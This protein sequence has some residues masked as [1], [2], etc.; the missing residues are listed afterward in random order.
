M[1]R[2]LGL[3]AALAAL[4][5]A[6][7]IGLIGGKVA[8]YPER[9]PASGDT[10]ALTAAPEETGGDKKYLIAGGHKGGAAI[11]YVKFN[12]EL[13][14]TR[15]PKRAWLWLGA[16]DED[17]PDMIE[18]SAVPDNGWREEAMNAE[19]APRLGTVVAS[20][21]PAPGARAVAFDVTK[22]VR[23]S[24][25][26]AFAITA[27]SGRD[28]ARFVARE[29]ES[30]QA[31][32]PTITLEWTEPSVMPPTFTPSPRP[33][34]SVEPWP[35]T[36]PSA[37]ASA[38]VSAPP[39]ASP[40]PS[41][42]VDPECRVGELLVPS[43]GALW[44]V[45]PGAHTRQ[46][47]SV[48]LTEFER[49]V[50]RPQ[51]IYHAYHRGDDLFPTPAEMALARDPQNPRVLL[52]N[53]KPRGATW[54]EIAAGDADIDAY[55]RRLAQH[56]RATFPERFFFTMHHEPENDVVDEEGSG[57]T[58]KDYAAAFRHV[59]TFLR[60]EGVTNL[61]STMCY[62]AYIPWNVKPWFTDLYPGDDVVDWVSWDTYAYSD[63]GYGHGD[64]AEMMNRRSGS[65]Q[66]WPGF[67][68]WAARTFPHKPL[69]LAEWGVWYSDSNPGHQ[70]E[71][72]NSARLQLGLFPRVKAYVYFESPDAEGRDSRVHNTSKG[73][74]E[75]RRF[76]EHPAFDVLFSR[77]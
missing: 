51:L 52:L 2:A 19:T 74:A 47:R 13:P 60:G 12:V 40:Q 33:S 4:A 34:P 39:S 77:F 38:S 49:R 43:C 28:S 1:K 9:I 57:M 35:N 63:P 41:G 55:L 62:M 70:A 16:E 15:Q 50:D 48:A 14:D 65:R 22:H 71:F 44:G 66:D 75:Y 6:I 53:W 24:G 64:F 76:S 17:L 56:L 73:L 72:F 10:F 20:V 25:V 69:M 29:G 54:G 61:V 31:G 42:P 7:V 46:D 11:S 32:A 68:N 3:V 27:P 23:S 30:T 5:A 18:L 45:A 8:P 37:S 59:I 21:E 58:A 67:Y 26:Y 36:S